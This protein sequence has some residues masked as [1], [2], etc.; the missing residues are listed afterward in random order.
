MHAFRLIAPHTVERRSVPQ[1]E[2]V[3]GEVLVRVGAAGV[4]H[5]DLHIIDAP[6][7]LGM[8]VPLALGHENA[9]WIEGPGHARGMG[10]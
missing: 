7:A 4:R 2:P 3:A 6:D 9:G 8:A 5:S 10:R 1:P